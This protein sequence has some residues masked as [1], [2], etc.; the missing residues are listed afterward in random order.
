M[1][2]PCTQLT[3]GAGE[4]RPPYRRQCGLLA[5]DQQCA[6]G[7]CLQSRRRRLFRQA[8]RFRPTRLLGAHG[9]EFRLHLLSF[10]LGQY[11]GAAWWRHVVNG[12][13]FGRDVR[14]RRRPGRQATELFRH[15]GQCRGTRNQKQGTCADQ[16]QPNDRDAG[17]ANFRGGL[18]Q[19]EHDMSSGLT[20][21]DA[22]QVDGR[23]AAAYY[24][25]IYRT[26]PTHGR[27]IQDGSVACPSQQTWP[28][29]A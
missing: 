24:P 3:G 16:P 7:N 1:R 18:L 4:R 12:R 11:R 17:P 25:A 5:R 14:T 22:R 13:V 27:Q 6:A 28:A 19:S 20:K 8:R 9:S 2:L 21:I 23:V 29:P 10:F 26:Y 15:F